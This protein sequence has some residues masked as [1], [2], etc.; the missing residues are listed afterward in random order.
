VASKVVCRN[1]RYDPKRLPALRRNPRGKP[2]SWTLAYD[3]GAHPMAGLSDRGLSALLGGEPVR[4][5]TDHESCVG[6]LRRHCRLELN[7]FIPAVGRYSFRGGKMTMSRKREPPLFSVEGLADLDQHLDA[8]IKPFPKLRSQ[9][10]RRIR[11]TQ[12]WRETMRYLYE[13]SED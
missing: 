7:L 6:G 10:V 5:G 3:G 8:K 12:L 9:R 2:L 1:G 11:R 13:G 4:A